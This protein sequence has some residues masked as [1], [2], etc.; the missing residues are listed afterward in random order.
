[1]K[2]IFARN[3]LSVISKIIRLYTWSDWSHVGVIDGNYVIEA[4]GGKGV[5][6]THIKA[7][8][9][10]YDHTCV[11]HIPGNIEIAKALI[12]KKFD[13]R[14]LWGGLLHLRI[15]DPDKWFC[16]ELVAH[17]CNAFDSKHAHKVSPE[18]LYWLSSSVAHK[19]G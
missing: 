4:I 18:N 7:F 2:V 17:A 13:Q 8:K 5:S 16:S 9:K 1:M 14:G 6:R 12:G 3:N 19:T 15:Q 11:R 10:R